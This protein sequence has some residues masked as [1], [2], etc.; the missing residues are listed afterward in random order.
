MGRAQTGRPCGPHLW[1]PGQAAPGLHRVLAA[2]SLKGL[3]PL[4]SPCSGYVTHALLTL[5]PLTAILLL[6]S[7]RLACLSHA[8]SVRSEP[9]SNSSRKSGDPAARPESFRLE[10]R[11]QAADTASGGPAARDTPC[12][13]AGLMNRMRRANP[14]VRRGP[15]A[16][17]LLRLR[18]LF[19]CQRAASHPDWATYSTLPRR[20]RKWKP[21]KKA[22][23]ARCWRS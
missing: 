11:T 12:V 7:V 4:L 21:A 13:P 6:R 3:L 14:A 23:T 9:G 10:A 2:L 19:T 1:S 16:V 5:S 8:A 18:P 22:E 15:R 17:T 20:F